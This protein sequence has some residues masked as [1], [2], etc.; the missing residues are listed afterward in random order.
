MAVRKLLGQTSYM[1]LLL[2]VMKVKPVQSVIA[3][4]YYIHVGYWNIMSMPSIAFVE[5]E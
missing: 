3:V 5:L 4:R 2:H 1:L